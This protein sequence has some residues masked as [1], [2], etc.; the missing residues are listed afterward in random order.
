MF[1][2]ENRYCTIINNY[3]FSPKTH[4]NKGNNHAGYII[5]FF[6]NNKT[7]YK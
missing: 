5:K 4:R 7:E 1:Y 6:R 3:T 2:S